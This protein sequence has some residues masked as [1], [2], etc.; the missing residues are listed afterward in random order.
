MSLPAERKQTSFYGVSFVAEGLFEKGSVYRVFREEV[1]PA[2]RQLRPE[3]EKLYCRNNGRPAIDPTLMVGV[4]ILQFMEKAPDRKAVDQVKLNL[5]WKY[6]LDLEW[7]DTGFHP[8]SLVVFR[9]R[10]VDGKAERI[11]LDAVLKKL[12]DR[13][14][15][16]K[17]SKQRI[18]STHILG[19]VS[20]MSRLEATRETMRLCLKDLMK[21]NLAEVPENW[22][23]W[24]ERYCET[25]V[26]YRQLK[27]ASRVIEKLK[28]TGEDMI[29]LWQWL[30]TQSELKDREKVKLPKRMLQEQFEVREGSLEVRRIELAGCI[31]NPH[32]P[33]A[34]W[35][36]KDP[37]KKTQWIGYKA[38]VVETVRETG[39]GTGQF[40]TELS[41]TEAVA[42]DLAGMKEALETQQQAGLE[43]PSHLYADSAY[44]NG[45]ELAQ[46]REEKRELI[47]PVR[48]SPKKKNL[49]PVERFDVSIAERSAICPAGLK[50]RTCCRLANHQPGETRYRFRWGTQCRNCSLRTQCTGKRKFRD[51]VVGPYHDDLQK[52]RREMATE[53]FKRETRNRNAIEGTIS[54]L[55]RGYG[56]RKA[57]YRGLDKNRLAHYFIAAACNV[58]RWANQIAR[59][60]TTAEAAV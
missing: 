30:E 23:A 48:G 15:V 14:L 10:L 9:Q 34:Q 28:Q 7:E 54:E 37:Q 51:I 45:A 5:G 36:N 25:E 57:R 27:Q 46:A 8:T 33:E 26:D 55:V 31:K 44:L 58:R 3:L 13:G 11:G 35:S 50:S 47:G 38:Q 39:Q 41:T 21:Q 24:I 16:R 12:V 2:L 19:N 17:R 32:D 60:V 42:S 22:T 40:I 6:A 43:A 53:A 52:R 49:F 18:D 56:L 1:L 29:A 4:T 59:P 20:K